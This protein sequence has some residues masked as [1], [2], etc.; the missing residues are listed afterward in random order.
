MTGHDHFA[1]TIRLINAISRP[2]DYGPGRIYDTSEPGIVA[3]AQVHATLALAAA[4]TEPRPVVFSD[5]VREAFVALK[6]NN[7]GTP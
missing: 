7:G 3:I 6:L 2:D 1:E 5:D 4:T